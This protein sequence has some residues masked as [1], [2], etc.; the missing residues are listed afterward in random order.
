M[1]DTNDVFIIDVQSESEFIYILFFLK[2]DFHFF[3]K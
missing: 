1:L 2:N 3:F